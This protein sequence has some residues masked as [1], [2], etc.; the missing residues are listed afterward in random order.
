[1]TDSL[2][3]PML[4][5]AYLHGHGWFEADDDV[6]NGTATIQSHPL[7]FDQEEPC[8]G[9]AGLRAGWGDSAELY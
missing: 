2:L 1:M 6:V 5:A 8:D 7:V 3:H 9:V 4:S